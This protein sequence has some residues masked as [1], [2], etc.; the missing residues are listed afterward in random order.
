MKTLAFILTAL[1]V[2]CKMADARPFVLTFVQSPSV[3][4][5]IVAGNFAYYDGTNDYRN[6]YAGCCGATSTNIYFDS[7]N[8]AVNPCLFHINTTG[9]NGLV[10][11]NSAPFLFDTNNYPVTNNS[12]PTVISIQ[13]ATGLNATP[14]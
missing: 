6:T 4:Q 9:T 14:Q 7:T 13:P 11:T 2:A 10:S 8:I 5:G 3:A 1:W 12:Q